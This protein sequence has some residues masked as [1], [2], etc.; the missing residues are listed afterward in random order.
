MKGAFSSERK[1]DGM[2]MT[3]RNNEGSLFR[4]EAG[5]CGSKGDKKQGSRSKESKQ[6]ASEMWTKRRPD[7]NTTIRRYSDKARAT[8]RTG[9]NNLDLGIIPRN[10]YT[11]Q[12]LIDGLFLDLKTMSRPR[13]IRLSSRKSEHGGQVGWLHDDIMV[14]KKIRLMRRVRIELLK[15]A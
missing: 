8:K 1:P 11:D 5:L 13:I 4:Q 10:S 7:D 15:L 6:M 2:M 3:R 9:K 12:T 14:S